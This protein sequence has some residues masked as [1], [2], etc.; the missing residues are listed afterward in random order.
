MSLY[1]T[2]WRESVSM[3]SVNPSDN[4]NASFRIPRD[5]GTPPLLRAQR[6]PALR[7]GPGGAPPQHDQEA[8]GGLH[9]LPGQRTHPRHPGPIQE[10]S[11]VSCL[12]GSSIGSVADPDP[13][14]FGPPGFGSGSIS[15][16]YGFGSFYHPAKTV[17]NT[18][19]P[20]VFLLLF[21]FL[22]LKNHVNVPWKSNKQKN[23]FWRLECQYENSRIR[24]R[25]RI[26]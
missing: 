25:I 19:I 7:A 15:H 17:R 6:P 14:V 22:S 3:D 4:H 18:L 12:S 16:K 13:Y 1:W 26:Y 11:Q 24:I 8:G 21:D 9:R 10:E 23:F 20:T 2:E 5:G